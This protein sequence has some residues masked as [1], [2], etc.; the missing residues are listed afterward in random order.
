MGCGIL[1]IHLLLWSV[2]L[3]LIG[4]KMLRIE[5]VHMVYVFSSMILFWL[6]LV[7]NKIQFPFP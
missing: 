5:K 6:G 4:P 1:T 2:I 3:M 7:R